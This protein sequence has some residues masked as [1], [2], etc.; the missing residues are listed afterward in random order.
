MSG[1]PLPETGATGCTTTDADFTV[2]KANTTEDAGE[3]MVCKRNFGLSGTS[4]PEDGMHAVSGATGRT[5]TDTDF[6][7]QKANS[8]TEDACEA[9]VCKCN[10]GMSGTPLPE[11][12]ATGCTTTDADFLVQKANTTTED[13][14]EVMV[15]NR[16]FSL[17]VTP[18]SEDG[19][20]AESGVIGCATTDAHFC[21]QK[22]NSTTED[23]REAITC[24]DVEEHNML[25]ECRY[26]LESNFP[27]GTSQ[28]CSSIVD[29]DCSYDLSYQTP[30]GPLAGIMEDIN[31]PREGGCGI[32][33]ASQPLADTEAG[34]MSV[35]CVF[36]LQCADRA[37]QA[38]SMSRTVC[39]ET[40]TCCT[41]CLESA[42]L[43]EKVVAEATGG[44]L[45]DA[46]DEGDSACPVGDELTG[47][48]EHDGAV[49]VRCNFGLQTSRKDAEGAGGH[50]VASILLGMAPRA[51]A[52]VLPS[53]PV[54]PP[55]A[56]PLKPLA[57]RRVSNAVAAE[58][59][60]TGPTAQRI[61]AETAPVAINH[62][63]SQP[64]PQMPRAWSNGFQTPT[65]SC[66]QCMPAGL[67]CMLS[68]NS[69]GGM[70]PVPSS[71]GSSCST[72]RS[73]S[74]E[75][76]ARELQILTGSPQN[77]P[78]SPQSLPRL[79]KVGLVAEPFA[80]PPCHRQTQTVVTLANNPW[81]SPELPRRSVN[82]PARVYPLEREMK[83][84][85]MLLPTE[86][87]ATPMAL[88]MAR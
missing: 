2:Q 22:A 28:T 74:S 42:P 35:E 49:S 16:N 48:P 62:M 40:S 52:S 1:T 41:N 58:V 29:S 36:D 14:G 75:S 72:S 57:K 45:V 59:P 66:R 13:A 34:D 30:V 10:F 3:V 21:V 39:R 47:K 68:S 67:T 83:R 17:S 19:T 79:K 4:L 18:L 8:T 82:G 63:M 64:Q 46:N 73:S 32:E 15:C 23:A 84:H 51:S 11:T 9:V 6:R 78:W 76:S 20:D 25:T 80:Q 81:G 5:T 50:R 26:S 56:R 24:K 86:P 7:V 53:K 33:S 70:K 43:S 85:S 55:V 12:G 71:N 87:I 77:I 60:G 27:G 44:R 69:V 31:A 38:L 88:R 54:M 61:R 37:A 65:S